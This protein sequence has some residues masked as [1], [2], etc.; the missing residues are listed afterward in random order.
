MTLV[1]ET[2]D[3]YKVL[4]E[5]LAK[6]IGATIQV[7]DEASDNEKAVLTRIE[8][9]YKQAKADQRGEIELKTLDDFLETL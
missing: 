3:Q 8:S 1:I 2:N 6:A 9:A 5:E 7:S 4:F